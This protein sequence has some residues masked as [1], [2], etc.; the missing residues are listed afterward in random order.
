MD[1]QSNVEPHPVCSEQFA[2]VKKTYTTK[3][4]PVV[5]GWINS[6]AGLIELD[7]NRLR[8]ELTLTVTV[9]SLYS[10]FGYLCA[11]RRT[12][13]MYDVRDQHNNSTSALR[14]LA[15]QRR[16]SPI[17]TIETPVGQ[18]TVTTTNGLSSIKWRLTIKF[19]LFAKIRYTT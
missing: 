7:G 1:I 5:R 16:S 4:V 15:R 17:K 13:Y 10:Y 19:F 12:L 3:L 6:G 14:R 2:A 18:L 9:D 8:V 11:Y